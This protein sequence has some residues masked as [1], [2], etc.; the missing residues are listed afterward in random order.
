M[1]KLRKKTLKLLIDFF[2]IFDARMQA[3]KA[4]FEIKQMVKVISN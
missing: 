3:C 2:P 1:A 4:K